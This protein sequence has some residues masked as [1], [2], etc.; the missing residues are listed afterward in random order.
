MGNVSACIAAVTLPESRNSRRDC[1][2]DLR[3]L[4]NE[5]V[6]KVLRRLDLQSLCRLE[7][8]CWR[9]RKLIKHGGLF[10]GLDQVSIEHRHAAPE[11][12]PDQRQLESEL[13]AGP[14]RLV[15]RW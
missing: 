15:F 12:H 10:R 4:P 3:Y 8:T 9:L 2:D 11:G 14:Q 1:Q 5:I 13:L 7:R 6:L